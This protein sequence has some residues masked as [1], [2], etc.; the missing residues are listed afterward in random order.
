MDGLDGA[1]GVPT[2]ASACRD[3]PAI[4]FVRLEVRV[5][6]EAPR[7]D[8]D[9]RQGTRE[10]SSSFADCGSRVRRDAVSSRGRLRRNWSRRLIFATIMMDE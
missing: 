7:A 1:F 8:D 5:A 3:F 9:G 4:H 10:E 2:L 6:F